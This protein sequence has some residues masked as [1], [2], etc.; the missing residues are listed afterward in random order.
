M[1]PL[2][3]R[4]RHRHCGIE[5]R[6]AP[7]VSARHPSA[8]SARA[9]HLKNHHTDSQQ[10]TRNHMR[11]SIFGPPVGDEACHAHFVAPFTPRALIG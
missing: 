6:A 10:H 1:Q 3:R 7:I 4:E 5:L 9:I 8:D 2:G 11:H